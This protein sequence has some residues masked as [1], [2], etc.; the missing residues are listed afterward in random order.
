MSR[1]G[2]SDSQI[3]II[4]HILASFSASINTVGLFGSRATGRYRANSDIDIV[5]YGNLD[6]TI[7]DRISTLFDESLLSLKVDV[8][9]YDLITYPPLKTHIDAVMLPLFTQKTLQLG[10]SQ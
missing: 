1:H 3:N 5:L 9:A 6:E 8:V 2:L 10:N 7:L 4:Q